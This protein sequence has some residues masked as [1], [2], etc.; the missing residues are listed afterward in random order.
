MTINYYDNRTPSKS[1]SESNQSW[2]YHDWRGIKDSATCGSSFA[3]CRRSSTLLVCLGLISVC[4]WLGQSCQGPASSEVVWPGRVW[5]VIEQCPRALNDGQVGEFCDDCGEDSAVL[6]Q[7]GGL[8]QVSWW[9]L[10][11]Q[12]NKIMANSRDGKIDTVHS[13]WSPINIACCYCSVLNSYSKRTG[14]IGVCGGIV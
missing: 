14:H 4:N 1:V 13:R 12:F 9:R 3:K 7:K 8:N 2:V 6:L 11:T 5:T 10:G